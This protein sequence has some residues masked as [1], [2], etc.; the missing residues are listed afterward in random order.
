MWVR[1]RPRCWDIL[2]K[3][4]P[5]SLN[6]SVGHCAVG[7]LSEY[8]HYRMS[9][10]VC[11]SRYSDLLQVEPLTPGARGEIIIFKVMKVNPITWQSQNM[12]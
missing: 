8:V 12:G 10:G 1:A 5:T 3:V 2:V 7:Q 11:L 9:I 6:I 4:G